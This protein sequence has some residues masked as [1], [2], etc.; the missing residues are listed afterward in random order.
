VTYLIEQ[1]GTWSP[2]E[3]FRGYLR[4]HIRGTGD[5]T[6]YFIQ[7][8]PRFGS[9]PEVQLAVEE[10][11]DQLGRFL[12]FEARRD[13]DT[14]SAVWTSPAGRHLLVWVVDAQH[15]AT[16]L[17]KIGH[18][19]DAVLASVQVPT[20]DRVSC[21]CIIC[22]DANQR[23]L[24]EVLDLRRQSP[25]V[26]LIGIDALIRLAE[27]AERRGLSHDEIVSLL[28]PAS[29]FADAV[30][31]LVTSRIPPAPPPESARAP[32]QLQPALD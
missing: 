5:L 15:A 27:T 12:G 17:G 23:L 2:R 24:T 16:R 32:S 8:V 4:Q 11:V 6:W 1:R 7:S 14:A 9:D 20:D 21:L 18:A 19:R 25:H 26:R 29:P 30:V 22:G 31:S 3:W 28:R 13:D 10:L